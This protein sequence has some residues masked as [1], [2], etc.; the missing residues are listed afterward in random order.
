MAGR[1]AQ[2]DRPYPA[3]QQH[4]WLRCGHRQQ[5]LQRAE[6]ARGKALSAWGWH[7]LFNYTWS[8]NLESNGNGDS[9]YNQNGGTTFPLDSYNSG[10]SAAMRRSTCRT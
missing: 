9:S 7:F 10:E 3:D 6:P 1:T 4:R 5:H 2:A 8:K